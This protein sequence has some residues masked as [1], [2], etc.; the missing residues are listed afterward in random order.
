MNSTMIQI[1]VAAIRA[2]DGRV[3]KDTPLF[4][5]VTDVILRATEDTLETFAAVAVQR[6]GAAVMNERHARRKRT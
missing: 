4:A 1:G 5:P 6:M 3:V 2:P